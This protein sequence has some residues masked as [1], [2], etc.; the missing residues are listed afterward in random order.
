MGALILSSALLFVEDGLAVER[1]ER[2]YSLTAGIALLIYYV[3]LNLWEHW[4]KRGRQLN[5]L[6]EHKDILEARHKERDA[7]IVRHVSLVRESKLLKQPKPNP[8]EPG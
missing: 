5:D 1:W 6:W 8:S 2:E 3:F 4:G 7:R